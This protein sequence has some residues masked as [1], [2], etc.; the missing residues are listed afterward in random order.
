[1]VSSV[2]TPQPQAAAPT[3]SQCHHIALAAATSALLAFW[4]AFQLGG[5]S[6]G[7]PGE[8]RAAGTPVDAF[9][10]AMRTPF[11][12]SRKYGA[13]PTAS[14]SLPMNLTT[15]SVI[16][17]ERLRTVEGR[18]WAVHHWQQ[19]QVQLVAAEAASGAE[20]RMPPLLLCRAD[21]DKHTL[22]S[23]PH[24][25][26]LSTS[27][28]TAAAAAAAD[29]NAAAAQPLS[30]SSPPPFPFAAVEREL[31]TAAA[32]AGGAGVAGEPGG[33]TAGAAEGAGGDRVA[34]APGAA[35]SLKE[36]GVPVGESDLALFLKG[37]EGVE[38]GRKRGMRVSAENMES[39]EDL[40]VNYE[41]EAD[42]DEA[43]EDEAD[44]Y[45]EESLEG[46]GKSDIVAD[47]S[48]A[49][50][51]AA[52]PAAA[53][54]AAAPPPTPAAATAGAAETAGRFTG[55][56]QRRWRRR[57]KPES[58]GAVSICLRP[59]HTRQMFSDN[60]AVSDARLLEW[61]DASLLMGVD[62]VYVYDR[63]ATAKRELLLPYMARGQVVHVPFPPWSEVFY[64]QEQFAGKSNAPYAAIQ[65]RRF[66]V[67]EE[68]K[69]ARG[70][71]V[72]HHFPTAGHSAIPRPS[73]LTRQAIQ[74]YLVPPL[75]PGSPFSNTSSLHSHPAG[76]SAIPRP[77]T[78][79]RQ[80][81]QQ[82]L[83]LHSHPAG[84]SAIPRPSTLTRQAIQQYLVPPLS[85]GRPFSNTS[86]LHSHPAGHS[87]IPRPSTLT[88][89][90]WQAIQ[91]RRFNVWG[92]T[93]EARGE[94]VT[95]RLMFRSK[96]PAY[97]HGMHRY[98]DKVAVNPQTILPYTVGIHA[99][100]A[101]EDSTAV[102]PPEVLR[103]SHYT[104]GQ[105]DLH[106]ALSNDSM[107]AVEDP[108]L[109]W[110]PQPVSPTSLLTTVGIH[111][112]TAPEDST[113]VA[114]PEVLRLNHY[115][116]GQIDL[117]FA[118]S[119]DST[120]GLFWSPFETSQN[121]MSVVAD[122]G[123]FWSPFETSQNSMSVVA[124]QGL[125]WSRNRTRD[126]RA[127]PCGARDTINPNT[128]VECCPLC[129]PPWVGQE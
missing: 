50:I 29:A 113:A 22:A 18:Q 10:H 24:S 80:A 68:T 79:T 30:V 83:V 124:D 42:E 92:E 27:S 112:T 129:Q 34:A 75:S 116:A 17:H 114:P 118:L 46:S 107:S 66:N 16:G 78:L 85:P 3:A 73:T 64:R 13:S 102:A 84:H 19:V 44:G 117:H 88:P 23:S 111:S 104:A 21:S 2:T 61:I 39:S 67:W 99:T 63:Y 109:F 101:P 52:A 1:M 128:P 97:D 9:D 70:E 89:Y 87:A 126:C 15:S 47:Y 14:P 74:Q 57:R 119:I 45:E 125:F 56:N 8:F 40:L 60:I 43:D 98:H 38:E 71:P 26:S 65:L 122:Q 95:D 93:K 31:V 32:A 123:L 81:I 62:R 35:G 121:S 53:A 12:E 33:K 4:V 120:K 51:T 20:L 49:V 6:T 115:T 37:R 91:L 59:F 77:S 82:Y 86:S 96:L 110:S 36:V 100:T 25:L 90:P 94:C 127:L 54:A 103:L 69:E 11:K 106:F 105:I 41:D 55:A 76:H 58:M 72:W 5:G 108:G 7:L 48:N 28:E